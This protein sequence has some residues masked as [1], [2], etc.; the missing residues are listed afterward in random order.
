VQKPDRHLGAVEEPPAKLCSIKDLM[1][2]SVIELPMEYSSK[3]GETAVIL[4]LEYTSDKVNISSAMLKPAGNGFLTTQLAGMH[5]DTKLKLVNDLP[6]RKAAMNGFLTRKIKLPGLGMSSGCDPEIFVTRAD[7][8]VFPAWEFMPDE[9]EA[10]LAAKQWLSKQWKYGKD[11]DGEDKL[12]SGGAWAEVNTP[13]CPLRV[14]AYWDGAQAEFAPWAKSCLETL[15]YGTREGLKSVL[16]FARAKDASAKL[17]LQNVVELPDSVLKNAEGKFIQFR[18]SESLNIYNDPGDGIP[19]AREY[20]YRCAGGHIH[21]GFTRAFTA[22]GIE[23]IIRGLD[24]ILGV[25]GVS[26]AA[27]IDNPERRHTYGRAGEFRLPAHGIEY[28]VLSNFWLSHPAISMLVFDLARAVVRLAE[29]GLY[30][31]CW[32]ASDDEIREVI[33]NCDVNGARKILSR[34]A[35]VISG[36]FSNM[37]DYQTETHREK[38]KILAMKTLLNGMDAAIK[39]P[40]D[41]EKNWKIGDDDAWK[42]HCRGQNDSWRS[43]ATA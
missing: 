41:V 6:L 38:M 19:N 32:V 27:G 28:R 31:L 11:D 23:Q 22:P 17:T 5:E 1:P 24:G 30:N 26:L 33:N 14:P 20:K 25:A 35:A 21:I 15:H 42:W 9:E 2:G 34:N 40:L 29:S 13:T 18:C 7:G 36:L 3:A 4:G 39:D 37:W 8:S 10:R 12:R 16:A 43:L